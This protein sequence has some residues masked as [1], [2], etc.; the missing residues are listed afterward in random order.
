MALGRPDDTPYEIMRRERAA[1]QAGKPVSEL[2]DEDAV[3]AAEESI[4]GPTG[5]RMSVNRFWADAGSPVVLRLP[6]GLALGLVLGALGVVLVAYLVGYS[7]GGQ[8]G[9]QAILDQFEGASGRTGEGLPTPPG[10]FRDLT[11]PDPRRIGRFYLNF[12]DFHQESS[13][14]LG[15][16]LAQ[17]GFDCLLRPGYP[18]GFRVY[19]LTG[20][21]EPDPDFESRARQAVQIWWREQGMDRSLDTHKRWVRHEG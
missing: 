20:F 16:F 12:G 21:D 18:D 11:D 3:E 4:G 19:L 6:R 1:A 14:A 8:A 10:V 9:R 2:K 15:R 5:W 13:R 7:R 17:Q